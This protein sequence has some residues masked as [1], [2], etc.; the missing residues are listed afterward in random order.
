MFWCMHTIFLC[1]KYTSR[2]ITWSC[3]S[4]KY[5]KF[6]FSSYSFTFFPQ[7]LYV[8][9]HACY[10]WLER[11]LM[12]IV[13]SRQDCCRYFSQLINWG[14]KQMHVLTSYEQEKTTNLLKIVTSHKSMIMLV[15]PCLHL[16]RSLLFTPPPQSSSKIVWGCHGSGVARHNL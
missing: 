8:L 9:Q 7:I 16:K 15:G 14:S 3:V 6:K 5:V 4:S 2:V 10:W 11:T 13:S 1:G 12:C